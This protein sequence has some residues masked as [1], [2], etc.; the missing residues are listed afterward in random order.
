MTEK[1]I[2]L[3]DVQKIIEEKISDDQERGKS[4]KSSDEYAYYHARVDALADLVIEISKREELATLRELVN[5]D[6]GPECE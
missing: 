1:Y 3:I 2:K 4:A 6:C 5:T